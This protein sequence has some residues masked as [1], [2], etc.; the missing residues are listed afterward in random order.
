L[1]GVAG[2]E[3]RG[4]GERGVAQPRIAVVPVANTTELLRQGRGRGSTQRP[5]RRIGPGLEGDQR[6][7]HVLAPL[8]VVGAPCDP[9]S[10]PTPGG[11]EGGEAVE[12]KGDRSGRG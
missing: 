1:F 5:A 7:D 4:Q 12:W 8:T 9:V 3:K 2:Q 6:S 10:P 11:G